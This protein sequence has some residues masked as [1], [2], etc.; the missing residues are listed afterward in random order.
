MKTPSQVIQVKSM[1][2]LDDSKSVVN[3]SS[4]NANDS[5]KP[6]LNH[7]IRNIRKKSITEHIAVSTV[8]SKRDSIKDE[9]PNFIC[10]SAISLDEQPLILEEIRSPFSDDSSLNG[11]IDAECFR[12]AI[13]P[14]ES[15]RKAIEAGESYR[16]AFFQNS[17]SLPREM[18][19]SYSFL[20]AYPATELGPH[21]QEVQNPFIDISPP[22]RITGDASREEQ[23]PI[24][25]D[26]SMSLLPY[27]Y[28]TMDEPIRSI[29]RYGDE[30]H[31][32]T[33][34]C[35]ARLPSDFT[36]EKLWYVKQDLLEVK[37]QHIK[38][39][40][41]SLGFCCIAAVSLAS[42]AKISSV[43]TLGGISVGA[44]VGALIS[45]KI[46][47]LNK[48]KNNLNQCKGK[49]DEQ[50]KH[51][52]EEEKANNYAKT[53]VQELGNIKQVRRIYLLTPTL[54]IIE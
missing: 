46:M 54:R 23:N 33:P 40:K 12:K 48:K 22:M 3:Q 32:G 7:S 53:I 37:A 2:N 25:R 51:Q 6:D 11:L 27:D 21:M 20:Q 34:E 39:V 28:S 18:Q 30:F 47:A 19:C 15:F 4:Q 36:L 31:T 52:I 14:G 8:K 43:L 45:I 9:G 38:T 26:T 1:Q 42:L 49:L 50:Y 41:A 10:Y 44:A 35:Y 17:Q 13:E 29:L 16:N 24:V 5:I